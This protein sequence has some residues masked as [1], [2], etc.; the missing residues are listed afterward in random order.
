MYSFIK[1]YH[2]SDLHY[3]YEKQKITLNEKVVE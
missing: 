1:C 3:K 2:M